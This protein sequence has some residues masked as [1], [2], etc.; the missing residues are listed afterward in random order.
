M[1]ICRDCG[2]GIGVVGVWNT[3]DEL[4]AG[5]AGVALRCPKL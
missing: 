2:S 4:S 1:V 5:S 3:N